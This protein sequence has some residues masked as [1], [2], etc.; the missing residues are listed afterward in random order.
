MQNNINNIAK[1]TSLNTVSNDEVSKI[2]NKRNPLR[3]KKYPQNLNNIKN[4]VHISQY[5]KILQKNIHQKIEFKSTLLKNKRERTCLLK[6]I[7]SLHKKISDLSNTI[8]QINRD[9]QLVREQVDREYTTMLRQ[10]G[11]RNLQLKDRCEELL[12]LNA[13]LHEQN[14][15]IAAQRDNAGLPPR[16]LICNFGIYGIRQRFNLIPFNLVPLEDGDNCTVCFEIPEEGAFKVCFTNEC[17]AYMCANCYVDIVNRN[18]RLLMHCI[19]CRRTPTRL[20]RNA[21]RIVN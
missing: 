6:N 16:N 4:T 20:Y 14:M 8:V 12:R 13:N 3:F 15:A 2:L 7:D 18:P 5:N 11:E 9:N 17:H 19:T 1:K 10:S 21:A